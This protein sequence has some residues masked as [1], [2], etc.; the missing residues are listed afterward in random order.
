MDLAKRRHVEE[1]TPVELMWRELAPSWV[2][3][4]GEGGSGSFAEAAYEVLWAYQ[5]WKEY[6]PHSELRHAER[7]ILDSILPFA[8][9]RT[10]ISVPCND[11]NACEILR[12]AEAV[13]YV[14]RL[15]RRMGGKNLVLTRSFQRGMPCLSPFILSR[16]REAGDTWASL[17]VRIPGWAK[18]PH[19]QGKCPSWPAS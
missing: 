4:I 2:G 13:V 6:A 17:C 3:F 15:C 12:R 18:C 1:K 19:E 11:P 16:L 7:A 8:E 14:G 9:A 5:A 10:R